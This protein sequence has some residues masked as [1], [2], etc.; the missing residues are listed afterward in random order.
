LYV[1]RSRTACLIGA[2]ITS[3]DPDAKRNR[4]YVIAGCGVGAPL[5]G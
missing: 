4:A 2:L 3:V 1:V 5:S